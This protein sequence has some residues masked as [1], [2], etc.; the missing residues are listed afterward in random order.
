MPISPRG[1]RC[2]LGYLGNS[3]LSQSFFR[4]AGWTR[5]LSGYGTRGDFARGAHPGSAQCMAM[6]EP[7]PTVSFLRGS[8]VLML[9][10]GCRT[11]SATSALRERS[12]WHNGE[13]SVYLRWLEWWWGLRAKEPVL[14]GDG[15]RDALAV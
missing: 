13:V 1:S 8:L 15:G 12:V 9:G 4:L 2:Q 10:V 14:L 5:Q 6:L 7:R 11:A 3:F